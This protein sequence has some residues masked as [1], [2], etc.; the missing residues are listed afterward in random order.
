M[1]TLQFVQLSNEKLRPQ[2]LQ[3]CADCNSIHIRSASTVRWNC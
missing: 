1:S 3:V 2:M